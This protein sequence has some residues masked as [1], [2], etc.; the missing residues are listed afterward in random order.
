VRFDLTIKELKEKEVPEL[1]DEFAQSLGTGQ[2]ETV[3]ALREEF[4]KK[5][6]E[7]EEQTASRTVRDQILG[8][9]LGKVNF[10]LSPRVIEREADRILQNLKR[11]FESQGLQFD[12]PSLQSARAIVIRTQLCRRRH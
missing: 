11:Q 3:D 2:F 10:E 9:I 8:K 4:R 1:N 12:K 5:L 6:V 7:R